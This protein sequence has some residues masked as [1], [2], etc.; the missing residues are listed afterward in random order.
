MMS[1]QGTRNCPRCR[2]DRP[3]E[4]FAWRRR[5]E[6]ERQPYCRECM[7]EYNRAHYRANP[8]IYL[9]RARRRAES[10]RRERIQYLLEYFR[11]HPCVDCGEADP[12][13]L[14]FDHLGNKVFTISE[15]LRDRAWQPILD[16]IDKCEVVCANCHRR[17]TAQRA[18]FARAVAA[19]SSS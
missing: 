13:V 2:N 9:R 3:I 8:D 19:A 5:S 6:G 17:R 14:E 11:T 18:G 7:A 12:L 16:E 10:V 15:G 4:Q 1:A